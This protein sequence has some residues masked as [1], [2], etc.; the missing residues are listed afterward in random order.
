[1][2]LDR[3]RHDQQAAR[4]LVDPVHDAGP[5][6]QSQLRVM[7]QE[8]VLQGARGIARTGM[9]HQPH[10]L[11]E[12]QQVAVRIP[13][14]ERDLLRHDGVIDGQLCPDVHAFP[15]E[16][17]VTGAR[18]APVDLDRPVLDPA[19]EARARILRQRLGEDGIEPY[20]AR[21]LGENQDVFANFRGHQGVCS[22]AEWRFRYTLTFPRAWIRTRCPCS[23][24]LTH[25]SL[26]GGSC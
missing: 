24:P 15:A 26:P 18:L 17:L 12:H 22:G 10:R 16:D 9:H 19:G 1:M 23:R 25:A 7:G 14:V 5:R 3:P 20:A 8:R 4:I 21:G 11:V 2:R 13:H 6:D